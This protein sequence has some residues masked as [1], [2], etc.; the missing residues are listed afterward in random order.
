[1]TE[2][3][4]SSIP[5]LAAGCKWGGT[6]EEPMVLFPEGAIRVGGSGL[7]I[8]QLCDGNRTAREIIEEL[9]ANYSMANAE[10]I[11]TDVVRFLDQLREK[12]I[13]DF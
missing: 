6:E 10:K 3:T 11:R 8:L 9:Q 12:R 13:V 5:R 4:E 2:L 1:V 7:H